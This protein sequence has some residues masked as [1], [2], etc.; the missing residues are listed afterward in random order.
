M[1]GTN[2]GSAIT[3]RF[4]TDA[5]A[6]VPANIVHGLDIARLGSRHNDRVLADFDELVVSRSR[7]F[8]GVQGVNPA[9]ENEMLEFLLMHEVRAIEIRIHGVVR[10]DLFR[11]QLV[12]HALE[13]IVY[14]GGNGVHGVSRKNS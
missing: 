13:G 8:A 5:G 12:T 10:A 1:V 9:F 2:V 14:R 3:A 4:F 11:L 7:N 6:A